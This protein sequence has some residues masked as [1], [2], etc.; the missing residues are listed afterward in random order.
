LAWSL[1][2]L[3]GKQNEYNKKNKTGTRYSKTASKVT[4][5]IC[6]DDKREFEIERRLNK[7]F[8]LAKLPNK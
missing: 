5:S 2:Q 3:L 1:A 7:E 4:N 8:E 6:N